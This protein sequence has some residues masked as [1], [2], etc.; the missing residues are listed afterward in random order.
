MRGE[1]SE[2][3]YVNWRVLASWTGV[4]VVHGSTGIVCE[5]VFLFL[6]VCFEFRFK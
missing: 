6:F 1:F 5:W 2:V 3:E 4:S